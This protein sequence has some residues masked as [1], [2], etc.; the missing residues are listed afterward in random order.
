MTKMQNCESRV[1]E[2]KVT[3]NKEQRNREP[4]A[5]EQTQARTQGSLELHGK[6]VK[7]EVL[8]KEGAMEFKSS[9]NERTDWHPVDGCNL[10]KQ[11]GFCNDT[12][13]V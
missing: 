13:L 1:A 4:G 11:V 9:W 7:K 8:D 10:G 2:G 3:G 6:C 12:W 5:Q